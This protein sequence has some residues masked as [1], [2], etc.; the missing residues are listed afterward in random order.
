M[1]IFLPKYGT[2]KQKIIIFPFG[3]GCLFAVFVSSAH[4]LT[5]SH[6]VM[7]HLHTHPTKCLECV[8]VVEPGCLPTMVTLNGCQVSLGTD[9]FCLELLGQEGHPGQSWSSAPLSQNCP[10]SSCL[11]VTSVSGV[12]K[13]WVWLCKREHR[14]SLGLRKRM[15]KHKRKHIPC[16]DCFS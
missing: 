13:G 5:C 16:C 14:Q 4:T 9:Q 1:L 10:C 3:T 15:A 2:E 7:L 6:W 11:R 8:V 12:P